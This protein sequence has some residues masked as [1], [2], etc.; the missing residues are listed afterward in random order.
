MAEFHGK[1]TFT[2][3]N[4]GVFRRMKKV[5]LNITGYNKFRKIIKKYRRGEQ[6][7]MGKKNGKKKN[8]ITKKKGDTFQEVPFKMGAGR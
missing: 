7:I 4:G 2:K 5:C 3:I 6:L 1:G 8:H